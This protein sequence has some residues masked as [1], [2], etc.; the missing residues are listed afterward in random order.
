MQASQAEYAISLSCAG[1]SMPEPFESKSN[2][3]S[4]N[5]TNQNSNDNRKEMGD[6]INIRVAIE[7]TNG[8]N[9]N[10]LRPP[11]PERARPDARVCDR[12]SGRW[13][14][15]VDKGPPGNPPRCQCI[16]LPPVCGQ[17]NTSCGAKRNETQK[18]SRNVNLRSRARFW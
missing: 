11:S 16:S 5:S 8:L 7:P 10:H 2:S 14:R 15:L 17:V 1:R 6:N 4:N 13:P 12:R 18:R 9:S 3:D